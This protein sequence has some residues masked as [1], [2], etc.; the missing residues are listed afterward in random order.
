MAHGDR[1]NVP[2]DHQRRT[3]MGRPYPREPQGEREWTERTRT[4]RTEMYRTQPNES[5]DPHGA[6]E[7][8]EC[9]LALGRT[10][11]G[12]KHPNEPDNLKGARESTEHNRNNTTNSKV[13]RNAPNVH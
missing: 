11:M 5:E 4:R 12:R 8:T 2:Y 6:R 10:V 7:W 13:H 3:G 1:P 9:T